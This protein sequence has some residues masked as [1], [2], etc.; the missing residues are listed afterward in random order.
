[1][2]RSHLA[3]RGAIRG[4][5]L[6]DPSRGVAIQRRERTA[7]D[8]D[9]LRRVEI[10][11][12]DLAL[13]IRTGGG[14]AVLIDAHAAYAER[15]VRADAA[16][17]DLLVLRVVVAIAREESRDEADVVR[18]IHTERITRQVR[19][20]DTADRGGHVERGLLD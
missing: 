3:G 6:N 5:D 8:L 18:E 19:D 16:D 4:E 10:E 20:G 7:E 14:N 17:R 2:V 13:S 1:E 11:L 15:R 12:R 9:A